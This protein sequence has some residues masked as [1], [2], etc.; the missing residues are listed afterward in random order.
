M[1]LPLVIFVVHV[2][3]FSLVT[4]EHHLVFFVCGGVKEDAPRKK[5]DGEAQR[6]ELE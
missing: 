2:P 5:I 3:S 4:A 1:P 6:E